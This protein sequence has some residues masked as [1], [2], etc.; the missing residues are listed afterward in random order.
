VDQQVGANGNV[1]YVWS[2]AT[3]DPNWIWQT[4]FWNSSVRKVYYVNEREPG[5]LPAEQ[6]DV[7]RRSGEVRAD[8]RPLPVTGLVTDRSFVTR[9]Q[10]LAGVSNGLTL[11]RVR[12]ATQVE[13]IWTGLYADGWTAPEATF[14]GP[15][16]RRGSHVDAVFVNTPQAPSQRLVVLAGGGKLVAGRNAPPGTTIALRAPLE[17]IRGCA[18]VFRT[19]PGWSPSERLGQ[20][21]LRQLGLFLIR[22]S[23][24]PPG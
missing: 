3:T 19:I 21:D 2:G 17:P 1:G 18:L 14:E 10:T 22:S 24:P 23:S 20:P 5:I 8:G 13:G 4:E 7:S 11:A 9:G 15:G 16:C 6:L 12:P